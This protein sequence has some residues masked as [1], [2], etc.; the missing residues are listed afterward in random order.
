MNPKNTILLV[1]FAAALFAFIFFFERHV[2]PVEPVAIRVM[3]D[4][5]AADVTTVQVQ[6]AGQLEIRAERTNGVWQLTKP[7]VYP[8]QSPAVENLLQAVAE[9]S[10]QARLT[11]QELKGRRTVNEDYGFDN[12]QAILIFNQGGEQR[13][14]RLG[15]L[16]AP[17][18]QI[19]AQV[20]G[21]DGVNIIDADFF[22]QFVP[23]QANDWRDTA[24]VNLKGEDFDRLT[25]ANGTQTFS[26]F[27]EGTNSVWRMDKP[28]RTRADYPKLDA[29]LLKLQNLRVT[30]FVRDD[31]RADLEAFGLQ[32]AGLELKLDRG[33]NHVLSLQFG[34]SPTN[35]TNQVYARYNGQNTIVLV[36]REPVAAWQAGFQEFRDRHLVRLSGEQPEIIE[37]RGEENF[38]LQRQTNGAWRVTQPVEFVAGTNLMRAF[39][40]NLTG[41]EVLRLN[42]QVAE[43]DAVLP[44]LD[45]PKY[46]LVTPARQYIL[47]RADSGGREQHRSGGTGFWLG[48][49]R[50]SFRAPGGSARGKFRLCGQGGR[51][52]EIARP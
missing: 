32:P 35:D 38:T 5:K 26:V 19:Y 4:F 42:N 33:T 18:D 31:D 45:F 24:F 23:R 44:E 30:R 51:L 10:P 21:L 50:K 48:Q 37:V 34:K 13:T 20:V 46:G 11:A 43:S 8:A 36:P 39:L 3:P 25:V 17:G 1:V 27:R 7:L 2:H 40:T 15:S 9:L 16:T 12:A 52:S 41:L 14:L 47:K 6:L 28:V 22:K 29:L 49:G